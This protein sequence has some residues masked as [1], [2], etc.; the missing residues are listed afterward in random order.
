M[1]RAARPTEQARGARV[2]IT[3]LEATVLVA[4]YQTPEVEMLAAVIARSEILVA[5]V[6]TQPAARRS[7][8]TGFEDVDIVI[9]DWIAAEGRRVDSSFARM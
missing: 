8:P 5:R 3:G 7:L 1:A 6:L 4:T 2:L 9:L